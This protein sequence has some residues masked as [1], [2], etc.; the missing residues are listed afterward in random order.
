MG[1]IQDS[2]KAYLIKGSTLQTALM[3]ATEVAKTHVVG[4]VIGGLGI[5]AAFRSAGFSAT[6]ATQIARRIGPRL[7]SANSV[8]VLT[9]IERE[10]R[11]GAAGIPTIECIYRHLPDPEDFTEEEFQ[12]AWEACEN[13]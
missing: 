9:E 12:R 7:A 8:Q 13:E 10:V 11:S 4:Q 2:V 1:L 3:L 5:E 6:T